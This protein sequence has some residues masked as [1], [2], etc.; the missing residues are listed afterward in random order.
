MT[1][2]TAE[3]G[4]Q[5]HLASAVFDH[6]PEQPVIPGDFAVNE[7]PVHRFVSETHPDPVALTRTADR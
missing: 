3:S 7:K 1:L 2:V 6:R 4:D 5:D